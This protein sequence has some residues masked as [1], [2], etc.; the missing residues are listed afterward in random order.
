[1]AV[2]ADADNATLLSEVNRFI[3][4]FTTTAEREKIE[5]FWQGQVIQDSLNLD[6]LPGELKGADDLHSMAA[7][8][9]AA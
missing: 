6:S 9:Q 1:M 5:R 3:Q 7:A 8:A 2:S 4:H